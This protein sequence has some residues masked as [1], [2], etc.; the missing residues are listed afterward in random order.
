MTLIIPEK[1]K[2][3]PCLKYSDVIECLNKYKYF[4]QRND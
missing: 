3:S 2:T 1:W 4:V